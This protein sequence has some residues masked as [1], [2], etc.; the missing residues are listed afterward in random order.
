MGKSSKKIYLKTRFLFQF[1]QDSIIL[2]IGFMYCNH[3]YDIRLLCSSG[4]GYGDF[5]L[6]IYR[7]S[8]VSLIQ[9]IQPFICLIYEYLKTQLT[10]IFTS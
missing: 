5:N 8:R 7:I 4:N 1:A 2:W 6:Q 3:V 9:D 10:I